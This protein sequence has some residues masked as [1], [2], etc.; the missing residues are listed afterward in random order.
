MKIFDLYITPMCRLFFVWNRKTKYENQGNSDELSTEFQGVAESVG[1]SKSAIF[2]RDEVSYENV[3]EKEIVAFLEQSH[4]AKRNTPGILNSVDYDTHLNGYGF[5]GF[6]PKTKRWHIYKSPDMYR[7]DANYRSIIRRFATYPIVI[8]H[9][10]NTEVFTDKIHPTVLHTR[11]NTHPFQYKSHVFVHNGTIRHFH[12]NASFLLNAIAP[13]LR[14]HILGNTDT[15]VIFYLFLTNI[16][17]RM[18][19]GR[20]GNSKICEVFRTRSGRNTRKLRRTKFIGNSDELRS[21]IQ[22]GDKF[23]TASSL[24]FQGV[25]ES[26]GR[27]KSAIFG[28]DEVSYENPHSPT[29][30]PPEYFTVSREKDV[31]ILH[32]ALLDTLEMIRKKFP[33]AQF[34]LV[35]ANKTHALFT[36][37]THSSDSSHEQSSLYW[38]REFENLRRRSRSEFKDLLSPKDVVNPQF[39]GETK[40]RTKF[41]DL[42][43]PK[44]V[45]N[46]QF[47]GET[48]SR[49][50]IPDA[51]WK[52]AQPKWII[53]SEPISRQQTL[54]PKNTLG[55]I[56]LSTGALYTYP[57]P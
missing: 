24:E 28:R 12:E 47:S 57:I 38:N 54:V 17:R 50:K 22:E 14:P 43:S 7:K 56:D 34:N 42:L 13:D 19:F 55:I 27:S 46:P 25:A 45:V 49:T 3:S 30:S 23:A 51:K 21:L 44:D 33:Y 15:E 31:D 37:Y 52:E 18:M 4:H 26:T 20:D 40:S 35:Y 32:G 2:G 6:Q 53:T 8:G 48:K 11:E 9:I 41:K 5:G 29:A 10:R 16:R 36:R 39:S 1:R